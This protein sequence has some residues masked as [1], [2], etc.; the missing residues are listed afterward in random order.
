MLYP[1]SPL[2]SGTLTPPDTLSAAAGRPNVPLACSTPS[3]VSKVTGGCYPSV[4]IGSLEATLLGTSC[5]STVRLARPHIRTFL[6]FRVATRAHYELVCG[7]GFADA[8]QHQAAYSWASG[9]LPGCAS[10]WS[11][12]CITGLRELKSLLVDQLRVLVARKRL[13]LPTWLTV[14]HSLFMVLS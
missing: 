7:T 8:V 12:P 3:H 9:L 6:L 11:D 1:M 13:A 5:T 2:I 10:G 4:V 14:F